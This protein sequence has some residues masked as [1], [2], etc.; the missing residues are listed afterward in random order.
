MRPR[1][2]RTLYNKIALTCF[3]FLGFVTVAR[4]RRST[5]IPEDEEEFPP[6]PAAQL[7]PVLDLSWPLALKQLE[8]SGS[9]KYVIVNA[10]NGLGNRLRALATAMSVAADLGRPVLLIWVPDLHC[11]CSFSSLYRAPLPFALMDEEIPVSEMHNSSF[12][13][14]NYMRPEPGAIKD[15]PVNVDSARHLYFKSGFMC[16]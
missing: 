9:T 2:Q 14:V 8:V 5:A 11:N 3:A 16:V 12:Q 4:L 1:Y 15:E 10:K 7:R 6:L 13:Q